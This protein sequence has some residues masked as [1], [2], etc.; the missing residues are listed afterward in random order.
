MDALNNLVLGLVYAEWL[1]SG[2]TQA[3]NLLFF[4]VV[5]IAKV[6]LNTLYLSNTCTLHE[7]F[8]GRYTLS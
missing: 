1:S 6:R 2:I 5:L 7:S 8:L 3:I 4:S